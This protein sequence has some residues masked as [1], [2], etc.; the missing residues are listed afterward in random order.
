M[1]SQVWHQ[2]VSDIAKRYSTLD[3]Q[4][5]RGQLRVD[6]AVAKY[7][8]VVKDGTLGMARLGSAIPT[9]A[10]DSEYSIPFIVTTL[11]EDRDGDV[12]VPMGCQLSNYKHNPV[13]Y[14]G[15]Q[16]YQHLPF[17]IAKCKSPDG[18]ITVYPE[19][20][21]I[22]AVFYFDREDPDACAIY[23]KVKRGFLNATSI[24]FVPIDAVRRDREA[25]KGIYE[26]A[27]PHNQPMS[28]AGW[29]FKVYDLTEISVVG[30]PAN[31]GAIRD[32]LDTDKD[33]SPR[34]RKGLVP[35]A[36]KAL[37]H[38]FSGWCPPGT[39]ACPDGTCRVQKANPL[40]GEPDDSE[41]DD[42]EE[43]VWDAVV[44]GEAWGTVEAPDEQTAKEFVKR[45]IE[46]IRIKQ[47]DA[48]Y[49]T[50][51][52]WC[53]F[54]AKFTEPKVSVKGP[55]K[56][57]R[58]QVGKSLMGEACVVPGGNLSK[59]PH[60]FEYVGSI[61]QTPPQE[62]WNKS[63]SS[64]FDAMPEL[65]MAEAEKVDASTTHRICAR[66][67]GCQIKDLHLSSVMVPSPR[68]GTFL[69]GLKKTLSEYRCVEIRNVGDR[70]EQPPVYETIQ[71]NSKSRDNFLVHGTMFMESVAPRGKRA[72]PRQMF[73]GVG[74]IGKGRITA[75]ITI[76]A[77]DESSLIQDCR[78]L[79][80]KYKDRG[81]PKSGEQIYVLVGEKAD[82]DTLVQNYNILRGNRKGS[83]P[84]NN[85]GGGVGDKR[86]V[87]K[88][89]P[90]WG[91]I[92]ITI[93]TKRAD[94]ALNQDVVDRTWAWA[95]DNNFLKGEAFALSGEF[96]GRTGE[97]WQD[98]FLEERNKRAVQRTLD[99]F[100][101]KGK[102][103]AN[104]GVILT[105]PPGT[106]KT[107]S[108]RIIR[109]KAKG[110]FIWVSSR[111]FHA[112][113]SVG[114]LS[115]AF[116]MAKEL[117]PAIIFMEDVDN[118][119][120]GRSVD[121][122]KSEMDGISRSKGVLTI[123]TTNFPEQLPE[124][125][126]DRPGRFHDVLNFDL[127]AEDARRD[128]LRKWLPTKVSD[129]DIAAAVDKSQGYS[130]AHVYELAHFAKTLH[131]QDG[132]QPGEAVREAL[133]KVESQRELITRLQ[134]SGSNYDP[135]RNSRRP[136]KGESTPMRLA[137]AT[138]T[139]VTKG[140]GKV[141]CR[142]G[143]SCGKCS[144]SVKKYITHEDGK[145]IVHAES[146]KVL[147]RHDTRESAERQL[148]AVEA[149]KSIQKVEPLLPARSRGGEQL[150][151]TRP[152]EEI[153]ERMLGKLENDPRVPSLPE[154]HRWQSEVTEHYVN[155][156]TVETRL[157]HRRAL[158]Q[159]FNALISAARRLGIKPTDIGSV[160]PSDGA[161]SLTKQRVGER[162]R[163]TAGECRGGTGKI[164][165]EGQRPGTV[166]VALDLGGECEVP[167]SQIAMKSV[168]KAYIEVEDVG[169][170]V[171][172]MSKTDLKYYVNRD[173]EMNEDHHAAGPFQ[174]EQQAIDW[175]SQHKSV[176]K[177]PEATK[178]A[179]ALARRLGRKGG[180]SVHKSPRNY[181]AKS[182]PS[183]EV[184]PDKAC[185][186]LEDGTID[187]KPLTDAQRGMFGAACGRKKQL[188][189]ASGTAGGYTVPVETATDQTTAWTEAI[190]VE[191]G[192]TGEC[193]GCEGSGQE[194]NHACALCGGSG[195][196][197]ECHG[198]GLMNTELSGA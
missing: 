196:C 31:A 183:D 87:I 47:M 92:N 169:K 7:A 96:L 105:G 68:M 175:A 189:E 107:L 116:E 163:V 110:T 8:C 145:W 33:L 43:N 158:E 190:C 72:N 48:D 29:L 1:V 182:Q 146:G 95:R 65:Q 154:W 185:R 121:L 26:R 93:I 113:G 3:S 172:L 13:C 73:K 127:P 126:I 118:W 25:E 180:K 67:L 177:S 181:L 27:H 75:T 188:A 71:L 44:D 155:L 30:V 194:D 164:V 165:R 184:S 143:G 97:D 81:S 132:M 84:H 174:T 32:W 178:V 58:G 157:V 40:P 85:Y 136:R 191:C 106:G 16:Q 52:T 193:P 15:H 171:V 80:V 152:V 19:D 153:F 35:Y 99:L 162:C 41:D 56:L 12:V 21:R 156:R 176:R 76:D 10:D 102:D 78:D 104:R 70:S 83:G 114:G 117:A 60:D 144:K 119:L 148:R 50:S 149:N 134:L 91:G 167:R 22:R 125:L 147:G 161:K 139:V 54:K 151:P 123:L 98:V 2:C 39:V 86:F 109:N 6:D 9:E 150:L 11:T 20:N 187:G 45:K 141:G 77:G 5:R 138:S 122:L 69:S 166:V 115:G 130:G 79:D 37:G 14:F 89:R 42:D 34:L 59:S 128:M 28:P 23:G 88:F 103:F 159:S 64:A 133:A 46:D 120:D 135:L 197:E 124:A 82:V 101:Q 170:Y 90:E 112:S 131:E 100:N 195:E 38:T 142:C 140:I 62:R 57:R 168:R 108:G 53:Q 186:I 173:G 74:V 63:L 18:R 55:Y 179:S 111:D 49:G 61:E 4:I 137:K 36:A 94:A 198:A 129:H 66:Y 160:L 24:A 17:P 51:W 192:G